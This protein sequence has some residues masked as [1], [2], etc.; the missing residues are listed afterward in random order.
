MSRSP[1]LLTARLSSP[2]VRLAAAVLLLATVLAAAAIVGG[3]S[4]GGLESAFAGSGLVGAAAFALLYAVLTVLTVPGA[5][6]TVAAGALYGTAGGLGVSVLGATAGA[7]L[8]FLVG[9]RLSRESLR[10]LAG[11]RLSEIDAALGRQGLKAVLVVRLV[12]LFPFNVLNYVLG[13]TAVGLR[14]YVLGTA[15]GIV[16]GA[17]AFA[18]L[19]GSLSRPG[20]AQF[21]GSVLLV[22]ALTAAGAWFAARARRGSGRRTVGPAA[23]SNG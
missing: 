1:V 19:G 6:L 17:L 2:R 8:A 11:P 13:A 10:A 7:T 21:V 15:V 3:P 4:A 14:P 18:S 9:R 20:S 23:G 5:T 12:P 16:P 22:I